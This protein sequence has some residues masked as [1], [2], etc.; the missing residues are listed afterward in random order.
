MFVNQHMHL[1]YFIYNL[2]YMLLIKKITKT[3]F[4]KNIINLYT[5]NPTKMYQL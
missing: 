1:L 5:S 2:Y 3:V 4:I